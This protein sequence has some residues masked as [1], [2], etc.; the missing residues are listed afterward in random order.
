M[1]NKDFLGI[2]AEGF[3]RIVYSEWGKPDANRPTIICT[4]GLLRNRHDFDALANYLSLHDR[5]VFCPDFVGRGDS[6]WF[7][8]SQHYNIEQY[9]TDMAVLI[10][11]TSA[12]K[13]DWLGTSIGGLV[14]MMMAALPN[15]PIRRLVLNDVGPQV[16]IHG[17]RR[18]AK[19]AF[20]PQEFT[21]KDAAKQYFK[22]IYADFG[23]LQAQQWDD[24]TEYSIR[25]LPS[26]NYAPNYDP[27]ISHHKSFP[28]LLLDLM[29]HPHK[30]LEG[31]VFDIDLWSVW[32]K[33]KC[34]I[35][36]I[37]GHHSDIL[38]PEHII[39]MRETHPDTTLI[40]IND[41][42]HAPALLQQEEHE[43]IACWLA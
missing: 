16:P 12:N 27:H 23:N 29:H 42:G 7:G 32:N 30:S 39:K 40:E 8:Q 20:S 2:S 3:H 41:A 25:Q 19:Y 24:F 34:P 17:L 37:H 18:L 36:I 5:H 4:H 21:T 26:G 43:K 33:I 28:Q 14:G 38:L 6:D 35:L 13:V 22:T 11:K 31:I 15:S 9:M 10:A 1:K